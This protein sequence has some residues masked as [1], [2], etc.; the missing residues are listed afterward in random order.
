VRLARAFAAFGFGRGRLAEARHWLDPFLAADRLSPPLRVR[1]LVDAGWLALLG[2]DADRAVAAADAAATSGTGVPMDRAGA[3]ALRGCA[4]ATTGDADEAGRLLAEALD[5]CRRGGAAARSEALILNHLGLL[6][7]LAGE[8]AAAAA[9]YDAALAMLESEEDAVRALLL[10]N[11]AAVARDVGDLGEVA[12]I[13]RDLLRLLPRLRNPQF[14]Q[15]VM[16][17]AAEI[18]A[19]RGSAERAARLLAASL[20]VDW[21]GGYVLPAHSASDL[22]RLQEGIEAQLGAGAFAAAWAAGRALT[23]EHALA[24]AEAVFAAVAEGASPPA[25]PVPAHGLSRRELEV[26]RLIAAGRSNQEIAEALF[27][28]HRT[29][30]T[31]VRNILTKLDLPSRTAVAAWAFR[32]G[33]A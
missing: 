30:T 27:I 3:L 33:L 6:A 8:P 4:A 31:H 32:H 2:G 21:D 22:A 23:L 5:M 15:G 24:E 26:V 7:A 18:A 11:R 12:A 19:A 17:D 9:H 16:W 20:R 25:Q 14:E 1:A 28:S 29:A 13:D 10:G